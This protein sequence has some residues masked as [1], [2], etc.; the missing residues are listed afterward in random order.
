[1]QMMTHVKYT[2]SPNPCWCA[3]KDYS[4]LVW[5]SFVDICSIYRLVKTH[6]DEVHHVAAFT[7]CSFYNDSYRSFT[8][9]EVLEVNSDLQFRI[10]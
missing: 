4:S 6:F 10:I 5:P 2:P 3:L 9:R 8:D 1:M 7:S